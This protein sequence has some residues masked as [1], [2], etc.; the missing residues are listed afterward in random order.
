MTTSPDIDALLDDALEHV[1]LE[2]Y[3]DAIPLIRDVL[4]HRLYGSSAACTH[5][6]TCILL[7]ALIKI[8]PWFHP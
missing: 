4:R 2:E 3:D 6:C 8:Q 1:I 5:R 7:L